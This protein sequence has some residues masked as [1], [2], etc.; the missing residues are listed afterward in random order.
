MKFNILIV[1]L[2]FHLS[3]FS[4]SKDAVE[5]TPEIQKKIRQDIEKEVPQLKQKLEKAKENPVQ[6][7]F[8]LDSCRV[9]RIM[10]KWHDLDYRDFGMRDADYVG[11]RI[12]DSV[13]NKYY[14]KLLA[15]LKGDDKKILIQAQKNWLAF[16]D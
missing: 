7:E 1:G 4:Q 9:E 6:I 16:R 8:T 10:E 15:I 5:V 12:Y 13:L 3:A 14:K 11:A 2:V